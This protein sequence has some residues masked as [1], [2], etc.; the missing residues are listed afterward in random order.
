VSLRQGALP[1][2]P[3]VHGRAG[4]K[5]LVT[6]LR[7]VTNVGP[8]D[9][10]YRAVIEPPTGVDMSVEPVVIRCS[11]TTTFR[12]TFRA[13]QW[14]QGGYIF[15]SL[16]WLDGDSHSVRIPVTVRTVIGDFIADTS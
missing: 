6:V 12:M 2:Q 4:P 10:T 13:K 3:P 1:P 5:G 7:T 11:K 14:V 16:T 15:G 8:A 9:T